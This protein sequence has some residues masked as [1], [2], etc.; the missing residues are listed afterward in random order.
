MDWSDKNR[1]KTG[2]E[3][4]VLDG[5]DLNRNFYTAIGF[6]TGIP[7]EDSY[8]GKFSTSEPETRSILHLIDTEDIDLVITFIEKGKGY[9]IPESW[10]HTRY[11]EL[12]KDL[13]DIVPYSYEYGTAEGLFGVKGMATLMNYASDQG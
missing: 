6:D 10:R 2:C 9:T 1:R 11:K 8:K 7:C 12:Y 13:E 5:I 3:S 4:D